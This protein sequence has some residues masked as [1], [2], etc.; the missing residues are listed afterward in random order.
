MSNQSTNQGSN[1]YRT[2]FQGRGNAHPG[3]IEKAQDPRQATLRLLEYLMPFKGSLILVLSF[4]LIYTLL[5]LIGPYLM[6]IAIDRFISSKDLAGLVRISILM[7]VIY[8]FSNAFQIVS[9]WIMARV[10]QRALKQMR[11]DL[12]QHLQT[13]SIRF[14]DT[15]PSGELMS[16]LTNDIDAINQ[17]V[18][19][20]VTALIASVLSMGGILI[21]MFGS[22]CGSR[23]SS[24][25][26]RAKGSANCKST[27]AG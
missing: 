7:L 6:G 17:A 27:W 13:L 18:S 21:A 24:P 3:K 22:C 26:T 20:N 14:F 23:T 16:R 10:S 5:G 9:N 15:H 11:R 19:Q 4:V 25:A 12:F 2:R 8:L 1:D